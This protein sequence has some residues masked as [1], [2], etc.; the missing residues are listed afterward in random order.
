MDKMSRNCEKR[1]KTVTHI[2]SDYKKLPQKEYKT[3]RHDRVSLI[4]HWE[5]YKKYG[6]EVNEKWRE[7]IVEK[8]LETD[9]VRFLR[10]LRIQTVVLNKVIQKCILIDI[11][12]PFDIRVSQKKKQDT[13]TIYNDQ[14]DE[15][16]RLWRC[17]DAITR[18]LVAKNLKNGSKI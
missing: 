11:A 17:K 15:I 10:N 8:Y 12:R 14:K 9:L 2:I 7:N 13:I 6:I 16:K 5:M 3:W 4:I 1:D 18:P